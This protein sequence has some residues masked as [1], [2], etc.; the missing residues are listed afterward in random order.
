M[1]MSEDDYGVSDIKVSFRLAESLSPCSALCNHAQFPCV[2]NTRRV[3]Q[4]HVHHIWRRFAKRN[5]I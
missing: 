1:C 3:P 2:P 5:S 4:M